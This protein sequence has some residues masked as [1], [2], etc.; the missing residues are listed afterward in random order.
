MRLLFINRFFYPDESATAQMLT[1]LATGLVTAGF[2]VKVLTG[3]ASYMEIGRVLP[4]VESYKGVAVQ[5]VWSTQF[6]RR[7]TLRRLADY[8][9][10]YLSAGCAAVRSK[11]TDCLVV[12]SD[13]PLLSV[14]AAIFARLK[15]W[16]TVCWL[17]DVFSDNAIR[18]GLLKEGTLTR[19]LKRLFD[20]S[21][22][23][24]HRVIVIGRCME[25]HLVLAGI[26]RDRVIVI[27][28]WAD[29]EHI[30]PVAP[31]DNWFRKEHGVEKQQVVVMYSGHL[32]V[33]HERQ[34][35]MQ[36][37]G[38]LQAMPEIR[39]L[40]VGEGKG[41]DQ[42]GNWAHDAGMQHIKFIGHQVKE[43][44]GYSLSAGDIHLVTLRTEM[45]GLSVPSKVYGIMAVGRPVVFIGPQGSEIAALVREAGCGE[46]FAPTESE[47]AALGI[48]DLARN[49]ERREHL[50]T[51]GRRYFEAAL[52]K[53][54]ALQRFQAV[55]ENL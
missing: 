15:G 17:H 27:P 37:I 5:R 14:L 39:V 13:P 49:H 28:N 2:S 19:I 55:F 34:S 18:A 36:V 47:K 21:L 10:F 8:V 48:F 31:N 1:D 51:S 54:L 30:T 9:S 25:R 50:G 4:T 53:K 32:G 42:L 3:R 33:V 40:I 12:L 29:G 22:A 6:G 38:A 52:E 26:S 41:I 46:V 45:E 16:K 23:A 43:H 35:L 7:S 11:N 44:V 20:W 24:C